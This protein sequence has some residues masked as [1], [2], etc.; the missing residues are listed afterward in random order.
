ML[1]LSG[2]RVRNSGTRDDGPQEIGD[3]TG[4]KR[5]WVNWNLGVNNSTR[6]NRECVAVSSCNARG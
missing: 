5:P 2:A 6:T 4:G 1:E 3:G